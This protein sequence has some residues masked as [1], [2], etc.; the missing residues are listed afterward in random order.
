MLILL[1]LE[2]YLLR[3]CQDVVVSAKINL[4]FISYNDIRYEMLYKCRRLSLTFAFRC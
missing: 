1:F 4:V 3:E 2:K